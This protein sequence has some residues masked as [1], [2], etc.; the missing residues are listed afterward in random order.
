MDNSFTVLSEQDYLTIIEVI[1]QLESCEEEADLQKLA[2]STLLPLFKVQAFGAFWTDFDLKGISQGESRI[3]IA[4]GIPE[5]EKQLAQKLQ[6][7][8]QSVTEIFASSLRPVLTHDIDIPRDHLAEEVDRFFSDHPEINRS[9]YP[10]TSNL[11]NF[12][13]MVDPPDFS[14]GIGLSRHKP[15]DQ[16]F[17]YRELR[18]AELLQPSLVHTIKYIALRKDL[19]SFSALAEHLADTP[20]PIALV[21]PDGGIMFR[22]PAFEKK[23]TWQP[24]DPLPDD[25]ARM[26]QEQNDVFS[27]SENFVT[28]DHLP[29]FY[30]FDNDVY[31]LNL[32]RLDL[33]KDY[34]GRCWLLKFKPA[35]EPQSQVAYTM[36]QAQLTTR[37]TEVAS[38]ACDGFTDKQIAQRLC[39]SPSTVNNHLKNIFKKMEVTSRVQLARHLQG[40]MKERG[41]D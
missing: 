23:F 16:P 28:P 9:E 15:Y 22:N 33:M 39:I 34:E 24:G 25:L 3:F 31:R 13:A 6:P 37:E 17:T 35:L 2:E 10:T 38:L 40:I 12:I 19:H 36:H 4:T 5:H 32:T 11:G 7:Y 18:M 20:N 29:L 30:R 14:I 26:V 41:K 21:C 1:H 27:P 8:Y